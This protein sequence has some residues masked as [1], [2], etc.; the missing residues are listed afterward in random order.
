MWTSCVARETFRFA[1]SIEYPDDVL[2][3]FGP[4]QTDRN[5]FTL[6]ATPFASAKLERRF[7]SS[8]KNTCEQQKKAG[9]LRIGAFSTISRRPFDRPRIVTQE[10]GFSENYLR[11]HRFPRGRPLD[12]P[13][14]LVPNFNRYVIRAICSSNAKRSII[15]KTF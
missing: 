2:G 14:E 13:N 4:I 7:S 10:K 11:V 9:R 6:T 8:A 15:P 3:A 1:R 12:D 5:N